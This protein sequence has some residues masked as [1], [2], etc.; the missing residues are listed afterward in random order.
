MDKEEVLHG[1]EDITLQHDHGT[2]FAV[3][4][5]VSFP[6]SRIPLTNGTNISTDCYIVNQS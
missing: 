1:R 4:S 5:K 3:N 6:K 2:S